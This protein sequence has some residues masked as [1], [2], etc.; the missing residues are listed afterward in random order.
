MKTFFKFLQRNKLYT[1]IEALGL[2]VALAFVTLLAS[3]A[4]TECSVGRDRP[5]CD[6]IYAIGTGDYVGMTRG[7]G[8]HLL[9]RML[10][11]Q[12]WTRMMPLDACDVD[13]DGDYRQVEAAAVDADFLTYMGLTLLQGN[14]VTALQDRGAVVVS[15]SFARTAFGTDQVL[16]KTLTWYRGETEPVR[17]RVA[18]VMPDMGPTD[19]FAPVDLFIPAVQA[20]RLFAEMDNF[21]TTL[22]FLRLVPGADA[23]RVEADLLRAYQETWDYWQ[24]DGSNG[25]FLYGSSIIPLSELYFSS[26]DRSSALRRGNRSTVLALVAV[27]LVLLISALFNY[28]NLTVAQTGRRAREMATRQLVGESRWSIFRRYLCESLFFTSCCFVLGALLAFAFRP[29]LEAWLSAHIPFVVDVPS[30]LAVLGFLLLVSLVTASVPSVMV[31]RCKPIDVVRG[32]FRLRGKMVTGRALMVVQ[33]VIS[34]V[35]VSMG[36]CTALQMRHMMLRPT[37]YNTDG[38]LVV[39]TWQ[40]GFSIDHQQLFRDRLQ[41]LPQV[42]RVGMAASLPCV[43]G[44]DGVQRDDEGMSWLRCSRVDTVAFRLLGFRIVERYSDPLPGMGLVTEETRDRYRVSRQSPL[45]KQGSEA[46]KRNLSPVCGVLANYNSGTA[47][48]HPMDDSHNFVQLIPEDYPYVSI[49]LI[50]VRGDKGA[51]RLAVQEAYSRTARQLVG[52]PLECSPRYVQEIQD[53]DLT[54]TRNM[55]MLVLVF[56]GISLLISALGLL[57]MSAYYTAQQG[58]AIVL[59]RVFGY[60]RWAVARWLSTRFVLVTLVA[61]VLASPL[62]AWAMQRYLQNFS[63]VIS[64]PWILIPLSAF[65]L[66][67]V[68]M[69]SILWQTWCAVSADP[70]DTLRSNE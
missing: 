7:T 12:S 65:I 32:D 62:S 41:T 63:Y 22:L 14:P 35:M 69:A 43:V 58:R 6:S 20:E 21:G 23:Q 3:Y 64:F 47:M 31:L 56:M 11:V 57:A 36:L 49:M 1:A 44:Y 13:V 4:C 55:M 42:E 67:L 48:E 40:L 18:G 28:V 68:A 70:V 39:H 10:A 15:E 51:A 46:N 25:A 5:A 66:L 37:G 16:G 26:I 33:G 52:L 19:L 61:V 60:S 8:D 2:A 59:R 45:I 34:M 17:L 38:L 29:L 50:K 54:G 24:T 9:A 30:V 53:E 27:A